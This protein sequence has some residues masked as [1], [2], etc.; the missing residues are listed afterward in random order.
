MYDKSGLIPSS[1]NH[2]LSII[3]CVNPSLRIDEAAK[4]LMTH[5]CRKTKGWSQVPQQ[6][7]HTAAHAYFYELTAYEN[8]Y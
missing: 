4:Q 3:K 1:V 2:V 6:P 5:F 8:N 7:N